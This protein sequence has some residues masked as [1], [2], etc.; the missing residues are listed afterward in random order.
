MSLITRC[1]VIASGTTKTVP[2][3][4][5]RLVFVNKRVA[6]DSTHHMAAIIAPIAEMTGGHNIIAII[7]PTA[8]GKSALAM[9]LARKIGAEILSVDSMQVYR[10]MD[11]GTAKP[12]PDERS[13]VR[14]YLIDV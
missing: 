3:A 1:T 8:S 6:S 11:I 7:G 5:N 10:R 2:A 14:H 4:A 12:S 9:R 13:R